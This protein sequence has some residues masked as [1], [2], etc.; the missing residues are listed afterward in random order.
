MR[1]FEQGLILTVLLRAFAA[2]LAHCGSV[3][4]RPYR[5]HP[6]S[7]ETQR[8][9]GDTVPAA[10]PHRPG[11]RSGR[12]RRG[13]RATV[14][15]ASGFQQ[16]RQHGLGDDLA[17]W[18]SL[19][20]A[21]ERAVDWRVDAQSPASDRRRE[22]LS[23][24]RPARA[25]RSIALRSADAWLGLFKSS[26]AASAGTARC[27]PAIRKTSERRRDSHRRSRATARAPTRGARRHQR[28][29]LLRGPRLRSRAATRSRRARSSSPASSTT[30]TRKPAIRL[31]ISARA[32]LHF[33][34]GATASSTSVEL[35]VDIP[36]ESR[37]L[38]DHHPAVRRRAGA[39]VRSAAPARRRTAGW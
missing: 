29:V 27:C 13:R 37:R 3:Q 22:R 25:D 34:P 8:L 14:C 12:A 11:A 16:Q 38:H 31:S 15:A 26:T 28:V 39:S 23:H 9:A 18:R 2:T 17:E 19:S 32:L 35:A 30:T 20:A 24:R 33:D 1:M 36:R 21:A 7:Q 4:R 10:E 6:I 5:R